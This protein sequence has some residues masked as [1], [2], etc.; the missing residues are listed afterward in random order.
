V[1]TFFYIV[2]HPIEY[3]FTQLEKFSEVLRLW[4]FIMGGEDP[5]D[6]GG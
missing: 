3:F 6:K 5:K 2:R 1:K 4:I